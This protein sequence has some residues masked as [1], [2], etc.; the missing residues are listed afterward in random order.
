MTHAEEVGSLI[1][2][3]VLYLLTSESGVWLERETWQ[4][5]LEPLSQLE[6]LSLQNVCGVVPALV[7][8]M[9]TLRVS[10]W[11]PAAVRQDGPSWQ[12]RG[13]SSQRPDHGFVQVW[14]QTQAACLTNYPAATHF[15]V[16][17]SSPQRACQP[18]HAVAVQM[19]LG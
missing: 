3:R 13:L 10:G 16:H 19:G 18:E 14:E 8:A 11:M 15:S 1:N 5:L 7:V 9:T 12:E 6:V 2:L 4:A 17:A